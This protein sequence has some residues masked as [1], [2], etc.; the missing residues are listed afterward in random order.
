M[1]N[2]RIRINLDVL[3]HQLSELDVLINDN[4]LSQVITEIQE[5]LQV[6][7][8]ITVARER[9]MNEALEQIE[10][11][12]KILF[13]RTRDVLSN[14]GTSFFEADRKMADPMS[15]EGK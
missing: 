7:L 8:G 13:T 9:A 5:E 4:S 14:T 10:A 3:N 1:S 2:G 12:K 11:S 6:S 15:S